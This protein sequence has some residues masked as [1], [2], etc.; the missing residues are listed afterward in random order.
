MLLIASHLD[1]F[2]VYI[3]IFSR[4]RYTF[5]SYTSLFQNGHGCLCIFGNH[6]TENS[7]KGLWCAFYHCS[8]IHIHG[9]FCFLLRVQCFNLHCENFGKDSCHSKVLYGMMDSR[10]IA[11]L[12]TSL[13]I[14]KVRFDCR[15]VQCWPILLCS[16]VLHQKGSRM[17]G[18][19]RRMAAKPTEW[20]LHESH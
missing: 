9:L 10:W 8:T 15:T 7:N 12:V 11:L 20:T 4:H 18:Q 14:S 19:F 13:L 2:V 6:S 5:Y 16:S 1:S 17:C 3:Q